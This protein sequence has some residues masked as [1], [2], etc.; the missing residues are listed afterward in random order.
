MVLIAACLETGDNCSGITRGTQI[1]AEHATVIDLAVQASPDY[2]DFRRAYARCKRKE[3]V[4]IPL[5]AESCSTLFISV[6]SPDVR[7]QNVADCLV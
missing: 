2:R 7:K 3:W 4:R 6:L 5:R 1:H